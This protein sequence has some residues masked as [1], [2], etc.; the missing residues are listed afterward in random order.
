MPVPSDHQGMGALVHDGGCTF[1]VWAPF[2]TAV[3][4]RVWR[5]GAERRADLASEANPGHWSAFVPGVQAGDEYRFEIAPAGGGP[6]F[7]RMDPYCRDA[8]SSAGNSIVCDLAFDW[9]DQAWSTPR[10]N[11][12]VI[13][14]LHVGTFNVTE[15]GKPGTFQSA[16]DR[17]QHLQDLGVNAV[18]ILP[19][20][21][22]DDDYSIGYNPALPFAIES[23]YGEPK[24]VQRFV[25]E[26]HARGIAVLLDVVYN[27]WG[28]SGL[29][30][31]L[32]R[33]DGWS[34]GAGGGIYFYNDDRR[35]TPWGDRPDYGRSEVRDYINDNALMWLREYRV[36][37][38]RWDSTGCC[39]MNKGFCL[40][41]CC[42]E[43]LDAG[44]N[45]MR[46]LNDQKNWYQPWKLS[47]AEDLHAF[48][49]M[50][51]PTPQGGAG[52][53]AQWD[54]DF[55][56]P[57]RDAVVA[58]FDGWRSM[59][60]VRDALYHRFRGDAFQRV[61]YVESHNEAGQGRLTEVISPGAADGW[62]AKKR[63]TLAAGIL[64]TA[65]GI[66]MFFQGAELLEWGSWNDR[67]GLDWSKKDR[68]G[69][70]FLL[71]R[72]L[73]R[74]RRNW[75]DNTRGLRGQR[76]NVH[77]VNDADKVIAYHRWDLGG[78]GD[79]VVVV[80][81]FGDRAYDS[82]R[83]GFPGGGTWWLRFNGD[84]RGY[85]ASFGD[86]PGYDTTAGGPGADGMPCAGNVGVGPYTLLVF[87]Q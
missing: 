55:V 28:P 80:A 41:E 53:D 9:G 66:P 68:F 76:V 30:D 10:W 39:R 62:F 44:W 43:W 72:D 33:F 85:D 7:T 25:R 46:F 52:F 26:A 37:G 56:Y 36:D 18:E 16:L 23:A 58:A 17:L 4:V 83:V 34:E 64:L 24:V 78:P 60:R 14:E 65:P 11:E 8:T 27:H 81:N 63:S 40:G 51:A 61:T 29:A 6:T 1:R 73:V 59:A 21:E 54:S 31:C 47:I 57:V 3:A 84:W 13:Y 20:Y 50:T 45:L 82:Y 69:G 87:S 22:F 38:L 71:Y 5:S 48:E 67:N 75:F 19:A 35:F 86:H 2:A 70:I 74:L 49:A 15:A 77:H 12:L 79:D 42:G 32:W